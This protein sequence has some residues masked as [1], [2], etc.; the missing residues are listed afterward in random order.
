VIV[1]LDLEDDRQPLADVDGAGVLA[2]SLEDV[3]A[4]VGSWRSNAFDVL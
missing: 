3:R 2:G 4:S 1:R